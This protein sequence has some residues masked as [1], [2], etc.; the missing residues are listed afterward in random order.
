M[1]YPN[2]IVKHEDVSKE[3]MSKMKLAYDAH[4]AAEGAV[5]ENKEGSLVCL[6]KLVRTIHIL[7][8]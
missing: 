8:C 5:V 6:F 3:N 4:K 1:D 7:L 2:P